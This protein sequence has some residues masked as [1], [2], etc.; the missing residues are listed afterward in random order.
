MKHGFT[1]LILA[2]AL[3]AAGGPAGPARAQDLFSPVRYV[4][5]QAI[6]EY[7]V[8]QRALFMQ[9]L[10]APGD[11]RTEALKALTE[12]RL[13]MSEAKRLGLKATDADIK[14]GMEEFAGRANLTADQLIA[15]LQKIGITSETFRDFI[16]AGVLWR[17]AVRARYI[18]VVTVSEADIDKAMQ[19][20]LRPR[21]LK[22]LAS[23]LVIPMPP[24]REDSAMALANRLSEEITTEAGFAAAARS[25]SAAPTASRGGALE[26]MPV[27]NL[28]PAIAGQIVALAKGQASAPIQVPGAVVLFLVRDLA[29]DEKAEPIAVTVEYARFLLPDDPAEIAKVKA[30]TDGCLD[31]YGLAKGMPEDRLV[32]ETKPMGDIPQDIGLELAKLDPGEFSTALT[33]SGLRMVLMLCTRT[34]AAETPPTRDEMRNVVQNQKLDGL[35]QGY[36]AELKSSAIIRDP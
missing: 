30:K 25:Y 4:N 8:I 18:G 17:Q 22:V 26:W 6:T 5:E 20:D 19:T 21:A 14:Q 36:L 7:E 28:P 32:I 11:P 12:D 16:T 1:A 27:A 35:A 31:L 9:L 15:E 34:S 10:R 13:R 2:V 23:E 29:R 24:G 33:R 3:A